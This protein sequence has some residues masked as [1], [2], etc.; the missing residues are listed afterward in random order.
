M[1]ASAIRAADFKALR[2]SFPATWGSVKIANEIMKF[3]EC[4]PCS[5]GRQRDAHV[6]DG[7]FEFMVVARPAIGDK[8]QTHPAVIG[9]FG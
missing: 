3:R 4:V 6:I 5:S 2:D 7:P 9:K 8:V 1:R